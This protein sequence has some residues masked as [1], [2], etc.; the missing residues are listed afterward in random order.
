M[1]G[2]RLVQIDLLG[3]LDVDQYNE[4]MTELCDAIELELRELDGPP[5]L[6]YE[7]QLVAEEVGFEQLQLCDNHNV[8]I[9][10]VC[11]ISNMTID[12]EVC[13]A[14]CSDC[15]ACVALMDTSSLA[16]DGGSVIPIDGGNV[17][18]QSNTINDRVTADD[19]KNRLAVAYDKYV[20]LYLN[21]LSRRD[22]SIISSHTT[23]LRFHY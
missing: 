9:C 10:P 2:S 20:I 5:T 3:Q 21:H 4:L 17:K 1:G 12:E 19:F 11:R 7:E 18:L 16:I 8:I 14:S 15:G 13:R 6:Y 22:L 23:T